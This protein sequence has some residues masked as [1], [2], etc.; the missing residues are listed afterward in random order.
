[1]KLTVI[2]VL[3]TVDEGFGAGPLDH[4]VDGGGVRQRKL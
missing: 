4:F 3:H 1:M 2:N